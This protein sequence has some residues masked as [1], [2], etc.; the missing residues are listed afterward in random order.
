MNVLDRQLK[1]DRQLGPGLG[2]IIPM[3]EAWLNPAA[4]EHSSPS[5]R[6]RLHTEIHSHST[7]HSTTDREMRDD[8]AIC[9]NMG[10]FINKS[11]SVASLIQCIIFLETKLEQ[12]HLHFMLS[13]L[14]IAHIINSYM[15]SSVWRSVLRY[16]RSIL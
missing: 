2:Q 8:L 7:K 14:N 12:L 15:Y 1:R 3:P 6:P 9:P 16:Q 5:G 4:A 13:F 11:C 10:P